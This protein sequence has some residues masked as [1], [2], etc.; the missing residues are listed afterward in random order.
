[1]YFDNIDIL[2]IIQKYLYIKNNVLLTS[3]SK[4]FYININITKYI[5]YKYN[6]TFENFK[7]IY[8]DIFKYNIILNQLI[9]FNQHTINLIKLN[10]P[11]HFKYNLYKYFENFTDIID[12]EIEYVNKYGFIFEFL[13]YKIYLINLIYPIF[14]YFFSNS[15]TFCLLFAENYYDHKKIKYSFDIDIINNYYASFDSFY[16]IVKYNSILFDK[17]FNS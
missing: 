4:F 1:M 13:L 12:Y 16:N 15:I 9:N 11:T 7:Y 17:F 2:N 14:H 10:F 6:H 3:T 5:I 8:T